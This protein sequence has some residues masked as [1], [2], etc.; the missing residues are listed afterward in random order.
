MTQT[1]NMRN[2]KVFLRKMGTKRRRVV[3]NAKIV[4]M[5]WIRHG[6]KRAWSI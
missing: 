1:E 4:D 5:T 2:E 3:R 6:D